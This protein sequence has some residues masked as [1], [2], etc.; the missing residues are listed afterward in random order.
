MNRERRVKKIK[1]WYLEARNQKHV[2]S[3]DLERIIKRCMQ[4]FGY[5]FPKYTVTKKGS[6][7][8]HHFN[9]SGVMP[10]S[11][12]RPHGNREFVP[13]RYVKYILEGLDGVINYIEVNS[14]GEA[15]EDDNQSANEHDNNS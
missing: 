14:R 9:V 10:I 1:E 11:I 8:V 6:C 4:K 2:H 7:T 15:Y 5:L 3:D 12:E 13:P